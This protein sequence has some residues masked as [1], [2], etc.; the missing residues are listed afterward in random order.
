MPIF[1][2]FKNSS[3]YSFTGWYIA[4]FVLHPDYKSP[5]LFRAQVC[6]VIIVIL[7]VANFITH[8]M[9]ANL[10]PAGTS[11]RNIPR[12]FLFELVSCPNY[13]IEILQWAVYT[14]LCQ[15][16][17]SL[18]FTLMGGG[19]MLIWAL[20]KHKAYKKEFDG[21]EGREQYPKGRKALIPFIL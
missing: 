21:K 2:L 10:R 13:F 7:M 19:Q 4:Y 1:N 14:V 6:A 18:V 15:S 12:G 11:I 16:V 5:S 17:S 3:Y 8:Y 20:G 9:L